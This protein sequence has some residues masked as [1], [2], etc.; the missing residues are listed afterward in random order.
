MGFPF[1]ITGSSIIL[2]MAKPLL[3]G[4]TLTVVASPC[5][6]EE[7]IQGMILDE[8]KYSFVIVSKERTRRL[9][10]NGRVFR[11][12]GKLY[13]GTALCSRLEDVVKQ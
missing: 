11:I 7:A 3:I 5:K 9:L 10:K 1:C 12:D 6:D 2:P 4:K 8:T 13:Q